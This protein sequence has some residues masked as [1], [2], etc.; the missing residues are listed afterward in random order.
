ML[1]RTRGPHSFPVDRSDLE[2]LESARPQDWRNPRPA[3]CYNLVVL[4]GGPAGLV[5]ARGA[6]AFGARVALVEDDMIG[7]DCLN[8]GCIPSKTIIRTSRLYADMENAEH[9]GARL[10]GEVDVDFPLVMD[11]MR[12]IRQVEARRGV[13]LHARVPAIALTGLAQPGDRIRALMAGFQV[14]LAKPVDPQALI[15]TIYT[16]SGRGTQETPRSVAA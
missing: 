7:G 2:H 16:L 14:H 12:R 1:D 6:V 15:G 5:A 4:G 10:D 13:A 8:V 9:F 11:R 3:P